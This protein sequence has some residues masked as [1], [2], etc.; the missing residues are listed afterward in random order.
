MKPLLILLC[1]ITCGCYKPEI[2]SFDTFKADNT[3]KYRL[4]TGKTA[5]DFIDIAYDKCEILE[6]DIK[7]EY[8]DKSPIIDLSMETVVGNYQRLVI[9]KE[10]ST[11][12]LYNPY[13]DQEYWYLEKRSLNE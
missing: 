9:K 4:I 6:N 2:I 1:L 13:L 7:C 5:T 11:W 12:Y 10:K 8:V 3:I